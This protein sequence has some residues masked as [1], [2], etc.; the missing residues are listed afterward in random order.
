MRLAPL[1]S[2][3]EEPARDPRAQGQP[4]SWSVATEIPWSIEKMGASERFRKPN[5]KCGDVVG[6]L[7]S[8]DSICDFF[9]ISEQL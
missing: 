4:I 7:S 9:L 6:M 8:P 5:L 2:L 3:H 1:L